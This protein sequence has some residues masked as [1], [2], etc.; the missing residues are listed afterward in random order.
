M[1]AVSNISKIKKFNQSIK[2]ISAVLSMNNF[3]KFIF[4]VSKTNVF[5]NVKIEKK[6]IDNNYTSQ[7]TGGGG[8]IITGEYQIC[9]TIGFRVAEH[10]NQGHLAEKLGLHP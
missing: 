3:R 10:E 4:L 7:N 9:S 2:Y 8:C 6:T 1:S 5:F